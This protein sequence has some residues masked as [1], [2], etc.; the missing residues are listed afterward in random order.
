MEQT[1]ILTRRIKTRAGFLPAGQ[2][3][4]SCHQSRRKETVEFPQQFQQGC[5]LLKSARVGRITQF[6][7]PILEADADGTTVEATGM[8]PDF[9]QTAVLRHGAV[10]AD[11]EMI[12]DS[13]EATRFMVAQHLFHRIVTVATCG[14]AVDNEEA[15]SVRSTHHQT[16]FHFRQQGALVGHLIPAD[17]QRNCVPLKTHCLCG[18]SAMI[19]N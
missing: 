10:L 5:F 16:A 2:V 13:A 4:V 17:N 9:Q 12:A 1:V 6:V 8:C 7:Q 14:G 18:V 11:I 19:K 3:P 15:D